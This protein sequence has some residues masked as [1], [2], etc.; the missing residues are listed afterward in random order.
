M[1]SSFFPT[2]FFSPQDAGGVL[3]GR[4]HGLG[5]RH[6]ALSAA[7]LRAAA[8]RRAEGGHPLGHQEPGETLETTGGRLI[9]WEVELNTW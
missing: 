6:R 7:A 2:H 3:D 5:L 1:G 4:P 9:Y 8:G